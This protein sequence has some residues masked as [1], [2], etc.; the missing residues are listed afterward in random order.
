MW[1]EK[2]RPLLSDHLLVA[3]SGVKKIIAWLGSWK[4][5]VEKEKA[6]LQK[7]ARK[8]EKKKSSRYDCLVRVGL[9]KASCG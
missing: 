6:F 7:Q 8:E 1:V 2:H 9:H 4:Q 5:R 3:K